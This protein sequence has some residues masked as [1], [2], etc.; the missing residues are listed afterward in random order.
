MRP[1]IQ[2]A[3]LGLSE[4]RWQFR[5]HHWN[6]SILPTEEGSSSSPVVQ[7]RVLRENKV[8][9]VNSRSKNPSSRRKNGRSK[10]DSSSSTNGFTNKTTQ[11]YTYD[12]KER[13]GNFDD[14]DTDASKLSPNK[15]SRFSNPPSSSSAPPEYLVKNSPK[16][17]ERGKNKKNV[18]GIPQ[19]QIQQYSSSSA[20]VEFESPGQDSSNSFTL[21]SSPQMNDNKKT[22]QNRN[23]ILHLQQQQQQHLKPHNREEK[24][25]WNSVLTRG[26][27]V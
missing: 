6:C 4:C 18:R 23:Q 27:C 13:I 8:V 7:S 21:S 17:R 16:L 2:G 3:K 11:S 22:N 12:Q 20:T 5:H 1:V 10:K 19:Q 25:D 26:V 15:E 14:D 9:T 24:S